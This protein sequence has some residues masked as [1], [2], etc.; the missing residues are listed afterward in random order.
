MNNSIKKKSI[1]DIL[2]NYHKTNFIKLNNKEISKYSKNKLK[3]GYLEE[4]QNDLKN[5]PNKYIKKIL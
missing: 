4:F 5:M 3:I 2:Q 1:C